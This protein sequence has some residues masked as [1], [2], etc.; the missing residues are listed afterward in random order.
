[1]GTVLSPPV[2]FY[3]WSASAVDPL[4]V[5]K[6]LGTFHDCVH[7]CMYNLLLRHMDHCATALLD[8]INISMI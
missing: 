5:A 4:A 6:L 7:A 2:K 1:M 8:I 3:R